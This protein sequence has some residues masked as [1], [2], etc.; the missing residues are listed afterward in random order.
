MPTRSTAVAA[1]SVENSVPGSI[2]MVKPLLSI[3]TAA[4]AV[5]ASSSAAVTPAFQS[6]NLTTAAS[7]SKMLLKT[8][9]Q[10]ECTI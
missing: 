8:P 6:A 3:S 4:I 2:N 5:A 7:T 10:L 9:R 1:A